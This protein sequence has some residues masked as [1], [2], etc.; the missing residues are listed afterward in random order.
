MH[1]YFM[2]DQNHEV[3]PIMLEVACLMNT[4]SVS[5]NILRPKSN[6]LALYFCIKLNAFNFF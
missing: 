2:A 4:N 6:E 1:S 3:L 5:V